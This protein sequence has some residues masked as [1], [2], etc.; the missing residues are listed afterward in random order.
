MTE[1]LRLD[2]P[3]LLPEVPDAADACVSRLLSEIRGRQG[4]DEAHVVAA[5]EAAPAQLCIHYDPA[6]LSMARI[7]EFAAAAGADISQRYGHAVWR[8]DSRHERQARTI[9]ARLRAV[10]GVLEAE[11]GAGGTVRVE[12]DR[13]VTGEPALL[14]ELDRAIGRKPARRAGDLVERDHGHGAGQPKH[15]AEPAH[16]HG[17][18]AELIFALVCGALL[19]VGFAIEKLFPL[20]SWVPLAAYLGAYVFGGVFTLREAIENLRL[21]RFEIDTLMLVAAAGAAALGA[22]AEGA[23]LLFLFSLGHALE[24]YAM[25]RARHAIEALADLAPR[26]ALVRKDG[27][28]LETPV[29]ELAI[30]DVVVVKPDA[31]LPADGFVINGVSSINHA[32]VTGETMPADKRPGADPAPPRRNPDAVDP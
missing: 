8:I 18:A 24:H 15:G 10:P 32:P 27:A 4:V 28:L 29:D 6:L 2:I 11:A 7:R 3:L 23:L 31:R 14:A 13:T 21:K 19:I 9:G 20:P 25:G 30:G 26:T 16:A 1:K 5:S 17:G 22:W 12:F